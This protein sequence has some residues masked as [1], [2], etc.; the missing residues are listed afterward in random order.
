MPVRGQEETALTEKDKAFRVFRL[1][2]TLLGIVALCGLGLFAIAYYSL[3]NVGLCG[4]TFDYEV[5]SP[6]GQHRAI[7]FEAGCGAIDA[8][9]YG[10]SILSADERFDEETDFNVLRYYGSRP[11]GLSLEWLS[12]DTLA[13]TYDR[14]HSESQARNEMFDEPAE[15][16][17]RVH[18][19]YRDT[20]TLSR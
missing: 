20:T 8:G 13:V 14:A 3:S 19:V 16:V 7:V 5:T 15:R 6:D 17:G 10:L 18:V 11:E 4:T 12:E 1:F 2:A 9:N